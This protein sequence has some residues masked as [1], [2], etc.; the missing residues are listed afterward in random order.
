VRN[1]RNGRRRTTQS[2]EESDEVVSSDP[3]DEEMG[4][5]VDLSTMLDN[6][7]QIDGESAE[8][9]DSGGDDEPTPLGNR[10]ESDEEPLMPS[11]GEDED[12]QSAALD[13]LGDFIGGLETTTGLKKRKADELG[14]PAE[15]RAPRKRRIL[16][17][18]TEGAAEGEFASTAMGM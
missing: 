11:D 7:A 8:E 18:R 10:E 6:Q 15:E 12:R 3:G 14:P 17:E 9:S 16:Q 2:D 4:G 1:G 5:M 13:A